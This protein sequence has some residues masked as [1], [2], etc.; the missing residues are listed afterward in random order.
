MIILPE[1]S[2]KGAEILAGKLLEALGKMD[3]DF[4]KGEKRTLSLSIG[5]AGLETEDDTIDTLVK[6]ADGAMYSSK[7]SGKSKASSASGA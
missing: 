1:T 5:I 4:M 3:L 7:Q 2:V 6:R